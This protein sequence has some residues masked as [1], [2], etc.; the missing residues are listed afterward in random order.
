MRKNHTKRK[1]QA[2]KP[3][4]GAQLNIPAP[5]LVELCGY[6]G[7]DFVFIDCEHGAIGIESLVAMARAADN[8]DLAAIVRVPHNTP[9]VICKVLDTGVAGII[10]PGVTTKD[11][12]VRAVQSAKYGPLGMRGV[13]SGRARGYGQFMPVSEFAPMANAETMVVALLEHIDVIGNLDAIL[14]VEG[15]DVF[16]VGPNDFSQSMGLVGQ[17]DHPRF[18]EAK[19]TVFDRVLGAGRTMGIRIRD[20]EEARRSLDRGFLWLHV[21]LH[22]M[23]ARTARQLIEGVGALV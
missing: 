19:D 4:L 5:D 6:A 2:G 18:L 10:V 7:F 8:Y 14:E 15:I 1:L 11:D 9:D 23:M 22:E 12:A 17:T 3:V 21:A 20:V 13:G 16:I